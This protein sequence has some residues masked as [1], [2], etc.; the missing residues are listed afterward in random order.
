M[1]LLLIL[2]NLEIMI[3][4]VKYLLGQKKK[5]KLSILKLL[6]IGK[7]FLIAN[8]IVVII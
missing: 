4:L 6:S 2:E 8:Q 7:I 5:K 3:T 1:V